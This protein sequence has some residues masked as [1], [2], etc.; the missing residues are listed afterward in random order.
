[1][2]LK[3]TITLDVAPQT[4]SEAGNALLRTLEVAGY[5]VVSLAVNEELGEA[6]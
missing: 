2:I 4:T 5:D 1:M 6:R 3:A